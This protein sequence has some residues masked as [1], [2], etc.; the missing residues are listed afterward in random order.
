MSDRGLIYISFAESFEV[1]MMFVSPDD[2]YWTCG[3]LFPFPIIDGDRD[4]L[5][6]MRKF[7]LAFDIG[8]AYKRFFPESTIGKLN[9]DLE[10]L[11][12]VLGT[13]TR[14]LEL[15][16]LLS[17]FPFLRFMRRDILNE[18]IKN[19]TVIIERRTPVSVVN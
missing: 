11:D 14:K 13:Q 7:L 18:H 8:R 10:K 2:R 1:G 3:A 17:S 15:E 19:L 16:E 9:L 5:F 12:L 4:R 6:K